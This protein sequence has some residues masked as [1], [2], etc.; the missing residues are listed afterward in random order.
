M[1]SYNTSMQHYTKKQD[2][3]QSQAIQYFYNPFV[4]YS[5]SLLLV[6]LLCLELEHQIAVIEVGQLPPFGSIIS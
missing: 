4:I 6:F 2:V 3:R 1:S 5:V